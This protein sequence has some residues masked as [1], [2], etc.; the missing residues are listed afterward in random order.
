M[1]DTGLLAYYV[2]LSHPEVDILVQHRLH[3]LQN[4]VCHRYYC[5]AIKEVDLLAWNVLSGHP[6][7]ASGQVTKVVAPFSDHAWMESI[8]CMPF[9][10]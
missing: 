8:D 10:A 7:A 9:L 5:R 2:G 4:N 1:V 3:Q 6:R